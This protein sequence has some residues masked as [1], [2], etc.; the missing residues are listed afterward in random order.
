VAKYR[1]TGQRK[2]WVAGG[3]GLVAAVSLLMVLTSAASAVHPNASHTAPFKGSVTLSQSV[4]I[5][6]GCA[7]AKL[8]A[9]T[10]FS[11]HTGNGGFSGADNAATCKSFNSNFGEV[12]G[13]INAYI[14]APFHKGSTTVYVN[15]SYAL[16]G[17]LATT[18]GTCKI[19]GSPSYAYCED[20]AAAYLYGYAYWDDL[21]SGSLYFI[22]Y[23][24]GS[25]FY[26][27]SNTTYNQT[28]WTGSSYSNSSS[29]TAGPI[30]ASGTIAMT[31]TLATNMVKTHKYAIY[32]DLYGY[33]FAEVY[34]Y[35]NG[36]TVT[37]TG[38]TAASAINFATL[39]NGFSI[40]SIGES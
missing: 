34:Y 33:T 14:N 5:S 3:T 19:S 27:V 20:Y 21:T 11:L 18:P 2:V 6:G 29:G 13:G 22:G 28:Y 32:V 39:G 4:S 12:Q 25:S 31:Y 38:A 40:T 15:G 30:T 10:A 26:L 7:H 37:Y 1:R 36:G 35:H 17:T 23:L 8:T 24:G 9:K 16:S